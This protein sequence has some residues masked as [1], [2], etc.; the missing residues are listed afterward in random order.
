[1][2]GHNAAVKDARS[3]QKGTKQYRQPYVRLRSWSAFEKTPGAS[4]IRRGGPQADSQFMCHGPNHLGQQFAS[5]GR[6][7]LG[8]LRWNGRRATT[9]D[10]HFSER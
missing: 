7:G 3:I 5:A 1:M 8:R 4:L 10:A 6:R 9:A 2:S